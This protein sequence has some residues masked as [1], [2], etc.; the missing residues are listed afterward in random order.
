M[1]DIAKSEE[2][3]KKNNFREV[4]EKNCTNCVNYIWWSSRNQ[5]C[6]EYLCCYP[7]ENTICDLYRRD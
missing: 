7:D 4:N 1:K 3:M 6:K 2:K 5:G